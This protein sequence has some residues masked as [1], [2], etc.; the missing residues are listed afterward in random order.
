MLS[1]YVD[2]LTLSGPADAHEAF[3]EKL[4]KLINVEPPEPIF[5]VLG[6]N[7]VFI[8]GPAKPQEHDPNAA[9]SALKG[10]VAFDMNDYARQTVELFCSMCENVSRQAKSCKTSPENAGGRRGRA[11]K[12]DPQKKNGKLRQQQGA[13]GAVVLNLR[14]GPGAYAALARGRA[15][16]R[17]GRNYSHLPHQ[18][19]FRLSSKTCP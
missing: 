10:A 14:R 15:A 13:D 18:I 8:D 16:A 12:L 6:R 7:H 17:A 19:L 11:K 1:T 4:T 9:V 2:D 3:C 5:R